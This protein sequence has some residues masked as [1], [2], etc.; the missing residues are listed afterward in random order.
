MK[1]IC[2]TWRRTKRS[3][4]TTA[5][6]FSRWSIWLQ[7]L[8]SFYLFHAIFQAKGFVLCGAKQTVNAYKFIR[9]TCA[10]RVWLGWFLTDC[11]H[12]AKFV[13]KLKPIA[14][15]QEIP[16][17][18]LNLRLIH[19]VFCAFPSLSVLLFLY[20]GH[21][22]VR[23]YFFLSSFIYPCTFFISTFVGWRYLTVRT[24]ECPIHKARGKERTR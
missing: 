19:F 22:F 21:S 1:F 2:A 7:F 8:F 14:R 16:T 24:I 13:F 4:T 9:T 15:V 11:V 10:H 17:K 6:L 20:L 23:I 12:G 18:H 3:K 5:L